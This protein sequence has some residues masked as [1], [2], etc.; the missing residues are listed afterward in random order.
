MTG[1]RIVGWTALF[2]AGWVAGNWTAGREALGQGTQSVT[3]S[4]KQCVTPNYPPTRK[5]AR[6]WAKRREAEGAGILL[7]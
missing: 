1:D 4:P 6:A 5:A 3:L 7:Q 2:V